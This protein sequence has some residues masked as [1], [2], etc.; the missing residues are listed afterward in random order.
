M[1]YSERG[2]GRRGPSASSVLLSPLKPPV[3]GG[4]RQ[5]VALAGKLSV[6][7]AIPL[8]SSRVDG[9]LHHFAVTRPMELDAGGLVAD[10]LAAARP[11]EAAIRS[12]W[13]RDAVPPWR[14]VE[15]TM[16]CE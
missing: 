8:G 6:D 9:M 7:L 16:V 1:T 10:L 15:P 14:R 4:G 11:E 13:Q 5:Q 3:T 12:R 2:L